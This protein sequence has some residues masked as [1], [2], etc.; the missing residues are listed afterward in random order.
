MPSSSPQ[1]RATARRALIADISADRKGWLQHG[2]AALGI[3]LLGLGVAASV[4]LT[5]AAQGTTANTAPVDRPPVTAKSDP[6]PNPRLAPKQDA[7]GSRDANHLK[8]LAEQ[9]AE[10]LA[11][12]SEDYAVAASTS[13]AEK[14]DKAL[15]DQAKESRE[16]A[17]RLA[18][19]GTARGNGDAPDLDAGA[20]QGGGRAC[21]PLASYRISARFGQVGIWS[22]YHTGFDFSAG[23]GSAIRSPSAGIVTNAGI[24][25]ASGWAGNYVAI[26]YPDG[27][28]TLM[29]HM[30]T[31]SVRVG[32]TV[33]ACQVVGAVGMTG[34]TFG[35]HLH[36]EA[37][38]AGITP[39]DIYRAVSP[40][41][42]LNARGLNP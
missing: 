38:P 26:K 16:A 39:G 7:G 11:E 28:Q 18:E 13:T 17:E 9:R 29:A 36:F 20:I 23:I 6:A 41:N 40:L 33:A 25:P 24:G 30:S 4:S 27:T 35:P 32:Q 22:R 31:V 1:R 14:R 8:S 34:R 2:V 5:G 10:E 19:Q 42:W 15:K 12:A 3:A 21:L 37:Y